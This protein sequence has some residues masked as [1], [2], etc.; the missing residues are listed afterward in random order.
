MKKLIAFLSILACTTVTLYAMIPDNDKNQKQF[1]TLWKQYDELDKADKPA[2]ASKKLMEIRSLAQGL[3]YAKDICESLT[4]KNLE[5]R[6][7][8]DSLAV[9]FQNL[10]GATV[11]LY[12]LLEGDKGPKVYSWKVKNDT[13]SFYLTDVR[14]LPLPEN[15]VAFKSISEVA[16]PG[17]RPGKGRAVVSMTITP[18]GTL[19]DVKIVRPSGPPG[20][21][22]AI[23]QAVSAAPAYWVPQFRK[24]NPVN[25][26]ITLP[27]TGEI[28]AY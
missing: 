20:L 6:S 16:L 17:A 22:E 12:R 18:L 1:S 4:E 21:D 7:G 8:G 10:N 5:V 27:V 23:V 19:T 3:D 25:I 13:G 28:G 26:N 15:L 14:T 11:T 9:Y 24:D 2:Q